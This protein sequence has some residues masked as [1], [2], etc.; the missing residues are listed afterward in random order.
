MAKTYTLQGTVNA[1]FSTR[2]TDDDWREYTTANSLSGDDNKRRIIGKYNSNYRA[3][4]ITF[5]SA[6]L[7]ALRSKTVTSVSL[8]VK[9]LVGEV[10]ANSSLF[11]IGFKKN[12]T[13][14]SSSTSANAYARESGST[15]NGYVRKA[16]SKMTAG[17]TYTITSADGLYQSVPSYGYAIG[18]AQNASAY[19]ILD[20]TATLT[21]T[22]N[23]TDYSITL[24]YNANGGSG[25][26]SA[27]T[28]TGTASGTPSVA[29]TV[30]YTK[31][32]RSNASAG[33]YT[34][35][36][37]A[38]GGSVS[39]ASASAARTTS[40]TFSKWNTNSGGSGTNYVGGNTITLSSSATLYAQWTS[41]TTTASVT[42]PTPTRDGYN[43]NGWYTAAS[44]G[45]KVGNAGASYT[46][47]GNITL[48]AQW[49]IKTY[50]VSYNAN[51]GS[52][53]PSSQTKTHGTD[54]TLSSTKPTK[55]S[56]STTYTVTYNANS[57]NVSPA[58][59]TATKTTTYTFSTWNTKSDGT[60]N[61]YSSGGKYTANSSATLY[62]RYT[63]STS[64]TSVTLPTP[65]R[66]GYTFNGWYTATSGGTKIGNGGASYTP[67]A[68]IIIYAQ[69]TIV[70]YT[71][72]YNANGGNSSSVPASQTKNYGATLTLSST[73]PTKANG[74]TTYT[75]TYNANEGSVGTASATATKTTTYTFSKWNTAANGS[76][77]NY[78][79]GASYTANANAT[80]YA[81]WTGSA[82]T[83]SVTLPT[84]S[85]TGYAFNGW[86]TAKSGGT[87]IGNAGASYT[88]TA[89]ITLYAQW[90][91]ITYTITYNKGT[92]G[93]GTNTTATK[94][95]GVELKLK[96]AIFTRTGYTQKGWS[97]AQAGES[98]AYDLKASYTANSAKTL[99][100]Y[101]EANTYAVTYNAN[102]GSGAPS[103]QTK[104]YGVTL[105]LS[106]TKPTRSG[107]NFIQWNTKADG[108]GTNYAS[109]GNYTANAAATLY[110]VWAA[111]ASTVSTTN[112]TLGTA[113]TITITRN[114]SS[115]T[116]NLS[117][118]YGSQTGTIATGVGTS[119]SWTPPT[120]MAS[121]FP[122][123][124]SG[125]CTI[126]CVTK[127]GST[128]IGTTTTTYTL[129]IPPSI[130]PSGVALTASHYSANSTVREWATFTKGYSQADL[131]VTY[132]LNGGA[133]LASITFSGPGMSS[134][135]TSTTARTSVLT[136]SGANTWT[137][138]VKDS[139][140]RTASATAS[141]T[142]YDYANPVISSIG[143]YRCDSD[144]TI[145]NGSGT[146]AKFLPKF[147]AS[148]VNSNNSVQSAK[149]KW[150]VSGGSWS[151]Q[152]NVTN[153]TYTAVLGSG[154]IDITKAYEVSVTVT[155]KLNSTT[156]T[157]TL[158][159][160]SGLWY[161]RGNDRLGLGGVPPSAGLHCDWDATFNGV[162]DVT[163]RRCYA[164][165]S[166]V[167]WYR[168][169][170]ISCNSYTEAIGAAGG[171]LRFA[172]TDSYASY[173]NDA[174][175]IDLLLAH[176]KVTFVNEASA[177][178]GYL[179]VDKIRYTFTGESP[180]N[181]Y[182]DIHFLGRGGTTYI[183][184]SFDYTGVGLGRQSRVAAKNLRF[185]ADSPS[186]ETVLTE[187]TFAAD[188][189]AVGTVVGASGFTPAEIDVKRSGRVVYVHFFVRNVS[190]A[191]NTHTL[192]GTISGVPLPEKCIRW[193]AGGGAQAYDAVTPVYAILDTDGSIKVTSPS[194]ISAVNITISYIV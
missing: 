169:C 9:L 73:T 45:T 70:K 109:G 67:T 121:A 131:S 150:R 101:W 138:T 182:V 129:S 3:V 61:S 15:T 192:I 156:A 79:A 66:T 31:P 152:I 135:G 92:Y 186:G 56:A 98:K 166:S 171:I 88:P 149:L 28:K 76:G 154:N 167:G 164:T 153:N 178:N 142:V 155:D 27:E 158:P 165:L 52:G 48:Y 24:S 146:Y 114:S 108:T 47:S 35:T 160:A 64:T 124:T 170:A 191:A 25:G 93:T 33:S 74:T 141:K 80:M 69:W 91:I 103:A 30:S 157:A 120:S 94:T 26:P 162:L 10:A 89:A 115:Y 75:V 126:T 148:S 159:S 179:E 50:T 161:G 11:K 32:T 106:S 22:T 19:I 68:N 113:Q 12:A 38:N 36:Y 82:S 174:H 41:S 176:N 53:A 190:I 95:Y 51:G 46:P 111:A 112:G 172:I 189:E 85:R 140:G 49:T 145:N 55:S 194:A 57:G 90:T 173:P 151:S 118:T 187:Y 139:R 83:T 43:F 105:P 104:T 188:T 39:P 102:G 127:S 58:N 78:A 34:V 99:Y 8:T 4:N 40:Y 128:T 23:E 13:A 65:T 44:G 96:D 133:T 137:V 183:G 63:S 107:Y 122:S 6:Q 116:H 77:T 97:T 20:T 100:P 21:V 37:N 181:G 1:G 84:P 5:D 119:Y 147:S 60:G 86:Y 144:G 14:S 17:N 7:A 193:L 168:V 117:Y 123:S 54:L 71:V 72:S 81:Q 18:V 2:W 136:T 184:I 125:T 16:S 185:V 87:K 163:Q 42:L 180:Y 59:A 132:T 143:T 130:K 134:T 175:T 29:F 110:A 177:A 62:A